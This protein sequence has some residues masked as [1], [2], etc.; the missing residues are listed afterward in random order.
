M[1]FRTKLLR[2]LMALFLSLVILCGAYIAAFAETEEPATTS[3]T[4]A[5]EEKSGKDSEEPKSEE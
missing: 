4:V 2:P 3:T 1:L 5:S